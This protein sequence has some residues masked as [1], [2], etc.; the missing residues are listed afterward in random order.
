MTEPR[1]KRG[2][3]PKS[4]MTKASY[5]KKALP[6]LLK[7][8]EKRCAYCLDPSELRHPSQ[9][10]VDHF[11]CKLKGRK[12]HQYSNLM[13]SCCT[14]NMCKHDK[15]IVNKFNPEQR[16]LNCTKENEFPKH[17]TE[18][19]KGEWKP[20]TAVGFYHIRAI[21]LDEACHNKKRL[22]RRN[23][24]NSILELHSKAIQYIAHNPRELHDAIMLQTKRILM[25]LENLPP[26]V[27]ESGV[28]SVK[29][30]LSQKGVRFD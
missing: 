4:T 11:D 24:A 7:D 16:L 13:L 8:F 19:E 9:N 20:R 17:I 30:W 12:R 1:V 5:R 27:T 22:M 21:G 3:G 2:I 18:N 25:E 6:H 15:P 10:H 14:C 23:L 26:M 29:D 28:V